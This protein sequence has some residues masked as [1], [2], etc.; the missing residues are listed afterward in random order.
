VFE[1]P[2]SLVACERLSGGVRGGQEDHRA[3]GRRG[4]L[5][6]T[7]HDADVIEE[8]VAYTLVAAFAVVW[9][10]VLFAFVVDDCLPPDWRL[11][12]VLVRFVSWVTRRK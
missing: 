1:P 8:I 11:T 9:G 12:K 2:P 6:R 7:D 5:G 10:L 4:G 3:G